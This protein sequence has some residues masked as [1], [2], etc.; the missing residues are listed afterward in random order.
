[1]RTPKAGVLCLFCLLL[2]LGREGAGAPDRLAEDV[3]DYLRTDDPFR[4]AEILERLQAADVDVDAVADV[5]RAWSVEDD[6]GSHG[7][8]AFDVTLP[9]GR[10]R[11]VLGIRPRGAPPETGWPTLL[12]LHGDL[13]AELE[14]GGREAIRHLG[15]AAARDGFLLLAPSASKATSWWSSRGEALVDATLATA[16]RRFAVDPNRVAVV[17]R[18]DGG[19]ACFHFLAHRPDAF[20]AFLS[21]VGNPQVAASL[22]GPLW[23]GNVAT[24]PVYA[25]AGGRDAVYPA[26]GLRPL[27][28]ALGRSGC[29][30][31]WIEEADAG[32]DL[33]WLEARWPEVLAFWRANPREA[34]PTEVAWTTSRPTG[35]RRAWLEIRALDRESASRDAVEAEL[36]RA[37]D[38]DRGYGIPPGTAEA[39]FRP[40]GRLEI[41]TDGVARLRIHLLEGLVDFDEDLIVDLDREEVFRGRPPQSL[42]HLLE[43]ARREGPGGPIARGHLD[44]TVSR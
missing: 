18:S 6:E 20:C 12:W 5:V 21:F 16:K 40:G 41:T 26:A 39:C 19:S 38:A 11:R 42:E 35:G 3:A 34:L 43:E 29:R 31:T 44:F 25:V 1:M 10:V 8:F 13:H 9:D 36:G 15:S 32:H 2:L 30:L 24:R 14:D 22:G 27:F 7:P 17:G 33:S 4:R 23:P 28:E 37:V